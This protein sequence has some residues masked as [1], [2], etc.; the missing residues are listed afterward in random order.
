MIDWAQ[1][2]RLALLVYGIDFAY[3][4]YVVPLNDFPKQYFY[5]GLAGVVTVSVLSLF[6]QS[7]LKQN[8][9]ILH[10][11]WI[12]GHCYGFVIYMAYWEP[13][14]YGYL[15]AGLH[16]AQILILGWGNDGVSNYWRADLRNHDSYLRRILFKGSN[17]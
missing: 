13:K 2:L 15:Q 14:S 12:A 1:R 9:I 5:A 3:S 17:R 10:I 6:K 7:R 8:L 11:L 4:R 16:I